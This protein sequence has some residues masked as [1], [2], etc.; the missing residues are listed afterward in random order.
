M[1]PTEVKKLRDRVDRADAVLIA[2]PEINGSVSSLILNAFVWLSRSYGQRAPL[3]GK[4]AGVLSASYLSQNQIVD[5]YEMG[6]LFGM[7]FY[8]EPFYLFLGNKVVDES[9]ALTSAYERGR[10][11]SWYREFIKFVAN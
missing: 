6:K 11:E 8:Q 5:C 3:E 7:R 9:G 2:T 4:R 1:L 10:L